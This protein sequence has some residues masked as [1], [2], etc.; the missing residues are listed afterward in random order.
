[1]TIIIIQEDSNLESWLAFYHVGVMTCRLEIKKNHLKGLA[2]NFLVLEAK[3]RRFT[4]KNYG[5]V[6][7]ELLKLLLCGSESHSN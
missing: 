6:E 5:D 3:V 1:M 2:E 7:L 4:N